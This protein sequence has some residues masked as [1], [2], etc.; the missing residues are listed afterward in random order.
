MSIMFIKQNVTYCFYLY[1]YMAV[2]F[3]DNWVYTFKKPN[4]SSGL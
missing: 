1:I 2:Q 3:Y 4:N